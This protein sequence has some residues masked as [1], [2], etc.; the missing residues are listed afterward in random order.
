M[1]ERLRLNS[2][3]VE[4]PHMPLHADLV[5]E[6]HATKSAIER[7]FL[8]VDPHVQLQVPLA[9]KRLSTNVAD[10]RALVGVDDEV[11]GEV[12]ADGED[13]RTLWAGVARGRILGL[14]F[15]LNN[16]L[17]RSICLQN[18]TRLVDLRTLVILPLFDIGSRSMFFL[19]A[20]R[21]R[22]NL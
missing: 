18:W 5:V 8:K 2:Q 16:W 6:P 14:G 11:A 4:V 21:F 20:H 13:P 1:F 22:F 10:E 9:I 19:H 3:D 15:P 7:L 12:G 17:R